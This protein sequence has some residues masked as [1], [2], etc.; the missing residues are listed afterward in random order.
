MSFIQEFISEFRDYKLKRDSDK[1]ERVIVTKTFSKEELKELEKSLIRLILDAEGVLLNDSHSPSLYL[2][3]EIKKLHQRAKEPMKV[4]ITGQ[5]SSGKSTFLNALLSKN[6]LPTG[7]T[8]V[9]SKVNYIRYGEEAKLQIRYK[10]GREEYNSI[11]NIKKFTDQREEV[12]EIDYLT[13]YAPLEM[14]KDIVFV[15]TPGLNSQ[16]ESDTDTTQRVLKDVDGI[17]WLTLIDNAGKRSEEKT[18]ESFLNAYQNKSLCVLNQKDKFDNIDEINESIN[19]VT[20]KFEKYFSEVVAISARQALEARS[21]DEVS[22]IGDEVENLLKNIKSTLIQNPKLQNILSIQNSYLSYFDNINKISNMNLTENSELLRESNIMRVLD[23]IQNE[24]QP[25]AIESKNYAIRQDLHRICNS[26][27]EQ[28]QNFINIFD[29]F[30]DMLEEFGNYF[31]EKITS[32]QREYDKE[33]RKALAKVENMIDKIASEIYKN[34]LEEKRTRY[35]EGKKSLLGKI[36]L[37]SEDYSFYKIDVDRI[38][39]TLFEDK[40]EAEKIYADYRL[41]L[42]EIRDRLNLNLYD[43]FEYIKERVEVKQSEYEN[44]QKRN[45]INSDVKCD[46]IRKFASKSYESILKNYNE[47]IL[48]SIGK[49]E[50]EFRHL[51]ITV[52]SSYKNATFK[53]LSLLE[54]DRDRARMSYEK[55]P[56]QFPFHQPTIKEI[57]FNLKQ[58]FELDNLTK[59]MVGNQSFI[60]KRFEAIKATFSKTKDE[61]IESLKVIKEPYEKNLV[62]IVEFQAKI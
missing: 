14:L 46:N 3:E 54:R 47:E 35:F 39:N 13:L 1:Q 10:D 42:N 15:D 19:Y 17:I 33:L 25:K 53:T 20:A 45:L 2:F 24:I 27:K 37:E 62:E 57:T 6:I 18:L 48:I 50:A 61:T 51:K 56:K 52:K 21:K 23:F 34:I 4:A 41:F 29:G 8:P 5:F 58:D 9:T 28:N 40:K 11:E 22:L 43:L 36:P 31:F 55:N 30:I 32:Y 7:I 12:E 60:N 26:L 16:S 38:V 59:I 49:V 44:Y